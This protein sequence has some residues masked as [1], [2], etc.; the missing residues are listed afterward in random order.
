VT[1]RGGL[2][3]FGAAFA[4]MLFAGAVLGVAE[5]GTHESIGLL[6]VSSGLS[7]VAILGAISAVLLARR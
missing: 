3:A 4:A 7:F 2:V 1:F 5:L 6:W